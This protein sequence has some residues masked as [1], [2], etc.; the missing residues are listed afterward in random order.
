[1]AKEETETME[2]ALFR[3]LLNEDLSKWLSIMHH[4]PNN[5]SLLLA[6]K[7]SR[8]HHTQQQQCL[9]S[10]LCGG[11]SGYRYLRI[12]ELLLNH[13]EVDVN[14]LNKS[15]RNALDSAKYNKHG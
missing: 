4:V 13:N 10:T 2:P 14:Y 3:F 6:E 12:D 9:H 15:G 7:G 1:V 11:I 8:P 5:C